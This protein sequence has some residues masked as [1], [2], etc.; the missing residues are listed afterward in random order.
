M[1]SAGSDHSPAPSPNGA[2]RT[3]R[4]PISGLDCAITTRPRIVPCA[5]VAST[6][7]VTSDPGR[8]R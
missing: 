5:R 7:N 8:S 2:A 4:V 3:R 6:S 1:P